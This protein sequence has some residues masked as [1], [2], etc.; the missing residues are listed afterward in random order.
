MKQN[1]SEKKE[2]VAAADFDILGYVDEEYMKIID[3]GIAFLWP[4]ANKK[5]RVEVEAGKFKIFKGKRRRYVI[6]VRNRIYKT[7]EHYFA[8]KLDGLPVWL[9]IIK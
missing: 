9:V 5:V 6:D 8:A 3:E 2:Q 1:S 4:E 7:E